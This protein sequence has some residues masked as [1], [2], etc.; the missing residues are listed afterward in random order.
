MH[1]CLHISTIVDRKNKNRTGLWCGSLGRRS[2]FPGEYS[3]VNNSAAKFYINSDSL[4]HQLVSVPVPVPLHIVCGF[5][6][7]LFAEEPLDHV[8]RHIHSG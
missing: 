7:Q 1:F 3:S 5:H 4:V 2:S 6:R 8:Q